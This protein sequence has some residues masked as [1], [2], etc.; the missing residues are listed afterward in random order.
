MFLIRYLKGVNW[1]SIVSKCWGSNGCRGLRG[2]FISSNIFDWSSGWGGLWVLGG[3]RLEAGGWRARLSSWNSALLI[4]TAAPGPIPHRSQNQPQWHTHTPTLTPPQNTRPPCMSVYIQIV[5]RFVFSS[6]S[7]A[8]RHF[9][10]IVSIHSS[11]EDIV[12]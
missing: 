8:W 5:S 12:Y 4:R 3:G 11:D 2:S 9:L 10:S 7:L 1:T 6:V